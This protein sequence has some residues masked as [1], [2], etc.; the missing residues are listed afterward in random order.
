MSDVEEAAPL[1]DKGT[2]QHGA[3]H[4]QLDIM[5]LCYSLTVCQQVFL[6]FSNLCCILHVYYEIITRSSHQRAKSGVKSEM[7]LFLV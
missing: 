2:D 7:V 4:L 3:S 1:V 5:L 6:F